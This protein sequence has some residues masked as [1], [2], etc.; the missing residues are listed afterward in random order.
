M[1]RIKTLFTDIGGVILTNGWDRHTRQ[2][3]VDHFHLEEDAVSE[4]HA[5]AFD[6]FEQGRMTL[7]E[8]LNFVI[9]FLPRPFSKE[10]FKEFMY[11]QSQPY[12]AMLD[13]LKEISHH[14]QLKVLGLSNEGR[15]LMDYRIEKFCLQDLIQVFVCSGFV[16]LRKPDPR[17]FKL[18]L[19]L[20]QTPAD[21]ILYIDD[22]LPF[23]EIGKSLGLKGIH[24]TQFE[25]TKKKIEEMLI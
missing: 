9:F 2:K 20:S 25:T 22:R 21:E 13:Y 11:A 16:G 12:L 19:D 23:V 8:Y 18:A 3:A 7:D 24:H 4:R 1:S 14:F 15:E 5:M 6:T 17:I 10:Q